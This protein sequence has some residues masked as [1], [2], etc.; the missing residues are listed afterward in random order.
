MKC[1]HIFPV[2]KEEYQ[3]CKEVLTVAVVKDAKHSST[4]AFQ[5]NQ[6]KFCQ[7][8]YFNIQDVVVKD[9]DN[10]NIEQIFPEYIGKRTRENI[11]NVSFNCI[12]A[13]VIKEIT[14]SLSDLRQVYQKEQVQLR[15]A[16]EDQRLMA[17]AGQLPQQP[18]NKCRTP[19]L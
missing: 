1:L 11:T 5:H 18:A 2:A 8:G 14:L 10:H 12:H 16:A 17:K 13:F 15:S 3:K 9:Q 7:D 6:N 4:K 19:C